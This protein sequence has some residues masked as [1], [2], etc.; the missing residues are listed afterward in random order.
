MRSVITPLVYIW[1]NIDTRGCIKSPE[2]PKDSC[3]HLVPPPRV[4]TRI[5]N[6]GSDRVKTNQCES[7]NFRDL[8]GIQSVTGVSFLRNF[9]TNRTTKSWKL[10]DLRHFFVRGEIFSKILVKFFPNLKPLY[11]GQILTFWALVFCKHLQFYSRIELCN[12]KVGL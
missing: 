10:A 3:G 7:Y 12:K 4:F 8:P 1:V 6:P 9:G 5:P 2:K 11:L